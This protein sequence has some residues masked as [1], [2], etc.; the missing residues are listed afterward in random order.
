MIGSGNP[1][2]HP[3]GN[4]KKATVPGKGFDESHQTRQCWKKF[5][6]KIVVHCRSHYSQ[7][8]LSIQYIIIYSYMLFFIVILITVDVLQTLP[9]LVILFD[10]S[11]LYY[12]LQADYSILTRNVHTMYVY[13]YI[14]IS[15][16]LHCYMIQYDTYSLQFITCFQVYFGVTSAFFC[17]HPGWSPRRKK[18]SRTL[19]GYDKCIYH[20]YTCT[21]LWLRWLWSMHVS[22]SWSFFLCIYVYLWV[23]LPIYILYTFN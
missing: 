6:E 11:I 10:I 15:L 14:Y 17:N 2:I 23:Y 1:R 7:E 4:L 18:S 12:L 13:I 9:I 21:W 8:F 16:Y 5:H 3:D 19:L 22:I 20:N